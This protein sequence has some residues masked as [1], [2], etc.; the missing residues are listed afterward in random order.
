MLPSE[1]RVITKSYRPDK[2]AAEKYRESE[3]LV[4]MP[5]STLV[6]VH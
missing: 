4:L 6:P 5:R 3:L 2:R 1:A